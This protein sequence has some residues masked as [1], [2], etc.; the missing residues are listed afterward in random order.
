MSISS[1]GSITTPNV[2]PYDTQRL[3]ATTDFSQSFQLGSRKS[4]AFHGDFASLLSA[5]QSGD[6]TSAQS[7]LQTLQSDLP[8]TPA[9]YTASGTS[10]SQTSV[11]SD[12]SSLFSAVKSGDLSAAQSALD[13]FK[14]D[15]AARFQE[16][17][18]QTNGQAAQGSQQVRGHHRHHHH[19]GGLESLVSS[20][21]TG[22]SSSTD[23]STSVSTD[24]STS[25]ATPTGS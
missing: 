3:Q 23:S 13:Q 15:V 16:N 1:I 18:Q 14:S 6:M 7:A 4:D 22:S 9:L 21:L 20:A 24:G 2:D 17:G 12:L 10:A 19:G 8:S 11:G 5:I 25:G